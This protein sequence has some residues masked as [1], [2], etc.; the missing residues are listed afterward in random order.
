MDL[1]EHHPQFQPC[2]SP[3]L[4]GQAPRMRAGYGT[5]HSSS[6][7]IPFYPFCLTAGAAGSVCHL[8]PEEHYYRLVLHSSDGETIASN[9]FESRRASRILHLDQ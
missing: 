3:D 8:Q 7:S 9:Y 6:I 4:A 1:P 5:A 2:H